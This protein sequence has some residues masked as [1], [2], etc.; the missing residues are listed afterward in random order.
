ML[1]CEDAVG[2]HRFYFMRTLLA[3][4]CVVTEY[5]LFGIYRYKQQ[6]AKQLHG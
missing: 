5:L 3:Y 6:H 2:H 1:L 4:E